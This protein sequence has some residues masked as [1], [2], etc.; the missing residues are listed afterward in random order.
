MVCIENISKTIDNI[1]PV[2]RLD[3]TAING[4]MQIKMKNSRIS[5]VDNLYLL[6]GDLEEV[7]SPV[8]DLFCSCVYS[9]CLSSTNLE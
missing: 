7:D 5:I 3:C 8:T 9:L 1:N 6:S 2:R 4:R